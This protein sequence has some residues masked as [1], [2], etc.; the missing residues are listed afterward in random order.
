MRASVEC[1]AGKRGGATLES[2][3]ATLNARAAAGEVQVDP[4]FRKTSAAFDEAGACGLLLNNL[5]VVGAAH[6]VFDSS[7]AAE[8]AG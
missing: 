8:A 6:L 4:L 3:V 7:D 1:G 2:N 5:S